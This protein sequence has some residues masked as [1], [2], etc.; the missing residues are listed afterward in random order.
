MPVLP[1]AKRAATYFYSGLLVLIVLLFVIHSSTILPGIEEFDQ[2]KMQAAHELHSI[3]FPDFVNVVLTTGNDTR[4]EGSTNSSTILAQFMRV[5]QREDNG[6][7][8]PNNDNAGTNVG[9]ISETS[10]ERKVKTIDDDERVWPHLHPYT[11]RQLV[12]TIANAESLSTFAVMNDLFDFIQNRSISSVQYS[13]FV[14]D[15]G[16]PTSTRIHV[17]QVHQAY[18]QC[19]QHLRPHTLRWMVWMSKE[20]SMSLA[21]DRKCQWWFTH[22]SAIALLRKRT[23]PWEHDVD[24]AIIDDQSHRCLKAMMRSY[25]LILEDLLIDH[26]GKP[27][28]KKLKQGWYVR[29]RVYPFFAKDRV[30]V[31]EVHADIHLFS[32]KKRH[33]GENVVQQKCT[34]R[35]KYTKRECATQYA[36]NTIFP[37]KQYFLPNEQ[38]KTNGPANVKRYTDQLYPPHL[39]FESAFNN[40]TD[41]SHQTKIGFK[42]DPNGSRS[43]TFGRS[44][45]HCIR[46]AHVVGWVQD[47]L[48]DDFWE[49]LR[50]QPTRRH[51]IK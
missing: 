20:L 13:D 30:A 32:A 15:S 19:T 17:N 27:R 38:Y 40:V 21:S 48:L 49:Y 5:K 26:R 39:L 12:D 18:N 22:G 47:Y 8:N 29:Y 35:F 1:K 33:E 37:L 16:K 46:L 41:T 36:Y 4:S 45:E 24:I 51:P 25:N 14:D 43:I 34:K 28:K 11:L 42:D 10:S 7:K 6:A 2:R 23:V 9:W 44:D 50:G 3:I 31:T